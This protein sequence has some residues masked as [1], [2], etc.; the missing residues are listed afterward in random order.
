MKIIY[1]ITF[2][3][4]SFLCNAQ[5]VNL[6]EKLYF[7]K[8]K[9]SLV[10]VRNSSGKIIIKPRRVYGYYDNNYKR[11]LVYGD[12]IYL[13]R[14]P[15]DINEPHSWGLAYNKKGEFLF[16]PFAFDNGP[17]GPAEG[18]SRFVKNGKIGFVNRHGDIVIDA[19]YDF[20]GI[21]NYGT[22]EYCNGCIWNY[23]N[24]HSFVTGGIWGYLDYKGN[25]VNVSEKRMS[26]K[27]QTIDSGK[28]LPY[29]FSYS[30]F[31]QKIIDSFY[32]LSLISKVHFVNF[33][34]PLDSNERKLRF[35]IVERPSSFFPYYY[36]AAFEYSRGDYR[37][38][39][40]GGLNFCVNQKGDKFFYFDAGEMVPLKVWLKKYIKEAKGY[41]IKHP[42]SPY[43][44]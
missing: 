2:L 12:I 18:L 32:K 1:L 6:K 29:Q 31:E 25:T 40:F 21:F 5:T 22:V 13:D 19:K 37:G 16:T 33:S 34:S 17:D 41:L 43:K 27:D 10:G 44:F 15:E 36:V 8:T 28:F 23:K 14:G 35:E 9:D 7:F 4:I 26:E 20:A 38:D 3:F 24:E 30:A 42:N 11:N 39:P